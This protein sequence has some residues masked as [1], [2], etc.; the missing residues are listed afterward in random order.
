MSDTQST[1]QP[2]QSPAPIPSPDKI[3]VT[4]RNRTKVL[5]DEYVKSVTSKNDTGIFD[6]LPEHSNF[7][8]L[9]SSPLTIRTLDGKKEEITFK[10]GII[11]VKDSIVHCYIDLISPE[12]KE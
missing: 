7:I 10:N 1:Q 12:A 11:K 9:I 8:S 2:N 4:V 6:V 3:H 5:F